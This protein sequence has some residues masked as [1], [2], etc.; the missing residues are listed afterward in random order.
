MLDY[1]IRGENIEVTDSLKSYIVEKIDK[2][3]KFF[4]PSQEVVVKVNLK[5]YREKRSKVEVTVMMGSVTL[6]AEDISQDMYGSIDLVVDKIQR[7]IR[8]HKTKIEKKVHETESLGHLFTDD[9]PDSEEVTAETLIRTK[10]VEIEVMSLGVAMM[11][12]D[13]L[14]HNFYIYKDQ[15]DGA[16]SILY[17][18]REGGLGVI[19]VKE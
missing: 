19:K 8:R 10:A 16:I 13:L 14:D 6:R 15:A 17:K 2:L 7:Q 18:R 5:V 11:Q 1:S 9:V 4:H 12:L 3:T